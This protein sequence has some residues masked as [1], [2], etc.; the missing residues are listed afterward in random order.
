LVVLSA[1][2]SAYQR[3]VSYRDR[4]PR[5]AVSVASP[6]SAAVNTGAIRAAL[7]TRAV[8]VSWGAA[9]LQDLEDRQHFHAIALSLQK[10]KSFIMPT[11]DVL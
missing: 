6:L 11:R 1:L 8:G 2:P 10:F 7:A 4:G 9:E 3:V 5:S